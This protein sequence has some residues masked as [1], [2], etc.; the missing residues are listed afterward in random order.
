VPT[1]AP[2]SVDFVVEGRTDEAVVRRMAE[3]VGV[4][5]GHVL[6]K[7]GKP[8]V[9]AS[10]PGLNGVA[11]HLPWFVL[12]DL[13][14][15][16]P[17]AGEFVLARLPNRSRL[18]VMRVA[19]RAVEAW[20]LADA[21][22]IA[23]L[24]S[25]PVGRIPNDVEAV[26]DPKRGIVDLARGSRRRDLR[27]D[28]PPRTGSGRQVGVAFVSTMLEFIQSDWNIEEARRRSPSL[29]R[30]LSRLRELAQS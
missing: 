30:A 7:Q 13:D 6:V 22:G 18:M 11:R 16:A 9:L 17:C 8:A 3:H 2:R 1:R 26:D 10:L 28:V 12:V 14:R 5:V 20:L 19:V 27:E 25:V 15:S 23:K 4:S 24:L 21:H 29:D